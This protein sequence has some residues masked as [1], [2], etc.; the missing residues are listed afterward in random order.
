MEKYVE[1][2]FVR[3]VGDGIFKITETAI[4]KFNLRNPEAIASEAEDAPDELQNENVPPSGFDELLGGTD[5]AQ[6]AQ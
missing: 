5:T 6:D 3:A 1:L 2:G 4:E